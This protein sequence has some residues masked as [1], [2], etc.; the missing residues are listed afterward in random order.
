VTILL[1]DDVKMQLDIER[2][3][4]QRHDVRVVTAS[5]GGEA[6]QFARSDRPSLVI[7]DVEPPD[8]AGLRTCAQFKNHL[9]TKSIP[10]IVVTSR[11]A[12]RQALE[13]GADAL[14]FK[15]V[16]RREFL[17]AA[18]RFV[19]LR[20]RGAPRCPVNLRFAYALGVETG[21]AF[22]RTLSSTGAY[23]K[24]DRRMLAGAHVVL[25][26]HL[27]G[28]ED[29]ITCSGVVRSTAIEESGSNVGP[30]FGVEFEGLAAG[31]R[32]RL[33]RFVRSQLRRPVA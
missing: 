24:S 23:L 26:F 3:F 15:P 21:Q 1:V 17:D 5:Q 33:E 27:P 28:E 18:R 22:S 6:L 9:A 29:E 11:N 25:R 7:V 31:D 13:A 8:L 12:G 14:V 16:V 19:S 4:F 30:G 32:E 20:E 10:V 2:T